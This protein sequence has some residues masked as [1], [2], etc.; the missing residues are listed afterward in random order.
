MGTVPPKALILF[1]LDGTMLID[2]A[3]AHG[4]AMVSAM[5]SVYGVTLADDAVARSQPWGKTDPQIAREVLRDAGLDDRRIDRGLSAWA[6]AAVAAFRSQ[7][8]TSGPKWEVRPGLAPALERLELAGMRLTLLTGNLRPI[9][10]AKVERMGLAAR[11]D[12]AIGAYGDDEEDRTKLVPLAR[13]RAGSERDPWPRERTA[14]V[15]DTP[16][17]VA[18]ARADRAHSVIFASSRYPP[19]SLL[20]ADAVITDTEALAQTLEAWQAGLGPT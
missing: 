6:D 20:G 4:R 17:D 5:R 3:Y 8:G 10:A 16:G 2:D 12:L 11:F 7:L 18:A 19:S 15:G 14:I 13:R 9:A 1:D